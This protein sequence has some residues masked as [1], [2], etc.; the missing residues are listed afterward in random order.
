[1]VQ[2]SPA[3]KLGLG[4]AAC[5]TTTPVAQRQDVSIGGMAPLASPAS[6]DASAPASRGADG[7]TE[8]APPVVVPSSVTA[9]G[10]D[11][12]PE[13]NPEP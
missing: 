10:G 12:P 9:E 6:D 2:T 3:P 4:G 11:L 5:E 13:P 8:D 7:A 1:M